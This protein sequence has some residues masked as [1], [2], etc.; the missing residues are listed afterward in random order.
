MV[1]GWRGSRPDVLALSRGHLSM[2]TNPGQLPF[3]PE[4]G[5]A[6][7]APHGCWGAAVGP[8]ASRGCLTEPAPGQG[9][10]QLP[11]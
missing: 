11:A 6:S 1:G 3:V 2:G 9:C 5:R 4:G 8:G 7:T 10:R